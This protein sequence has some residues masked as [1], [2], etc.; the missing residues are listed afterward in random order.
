MLMKLF[1]LILSGI[2]MKSPD[3]LKKIDRKVEVK[4]KGNLAVT[5]CAIINLVSLYSTFINV[6]VNRNYRQVKG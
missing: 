1:K 4:V 6:F 2:D 5:I 3:E